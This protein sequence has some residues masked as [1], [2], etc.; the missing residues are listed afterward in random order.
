MARRIGNKNLHYAPLTKDELGV[1][2]LT[3]GKP[4]R[5][6]KVISFKTSDE[7]ADYT[8]YSD[9]GVEETGKRLVKSEI[10]IEVG[11]IQNK[12]KAALTGIKYDESTGKT[13]KNTNVSQPAIALM[14]EMSKSDGA[15]SDYRVLYKCI[16]SIEESE[17]TTIEDGVESN[18][19]VLKGT[20]IPTINTGD[21]DMEIDGEDAAEGA[22]AIIEDFFTEVQ[23]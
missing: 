10:E 18:T 17:S 19:F 5:I 1:G 3:Y 9:D 2:G 11:Y 13:Y 21:L 15:K 6:P 8:F 14:Y 20:A 12:L 7:Y 23:L 4:E 22:A 16:L